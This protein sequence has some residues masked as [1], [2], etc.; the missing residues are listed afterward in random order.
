LLN[1]HG[2]LK[3]QQKARWN[4]SIARPPLKQNNKIQKK[5]PH[6]AISLVGIDP[7]IQF[8]GLSMK[9]HADTLITMV[10]IISYIKLEKFTNYVDK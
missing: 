6:I 1:I 7:S 10:T 5:R 9:P 2:V 8:Y 3:A 4:H